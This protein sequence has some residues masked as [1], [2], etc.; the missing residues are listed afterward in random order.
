MHPHY[1]LMN[2]TTNPN[3]RIKDVFGFALGLPNGLRYPRWGGRRDAV[4]LEKG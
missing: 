2:S 4:R 3:L 1:Y